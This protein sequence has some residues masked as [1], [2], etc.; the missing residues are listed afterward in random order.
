MPAQPFTVHVDTDELAE[1]IVAGPEAPAAA[2]TESRRDRRKR[3]QGR[4]GDERLAA[5]LSSER[6]HGNRAA[7]VGQGRSYAFRR[8]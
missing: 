4:A 8:S 3:A 5:R 1:P 6:S 2:G 7:G